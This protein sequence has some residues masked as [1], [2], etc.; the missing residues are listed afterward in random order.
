MSDGRAV[1]ERRELSPADLAEVQ[2]MGKKARNAAITA[3]LAAIF[4]RHEGEFVD[5]LAARVGADVRKVWTPTAEGYFARLP[6]ATLDRIWAELVPSLD[7]LEGAFL[8]QKKAEK[9][10][11]LDKLFNSSDYREAM[12]LDRA[13]CQRIDQWLPAELRFG[14]VAA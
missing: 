6:V 8:S 3:A 12:R 10:K 5:H 9:V 4:C 13:A 11:D 2:A 7:G 1:G 14:E